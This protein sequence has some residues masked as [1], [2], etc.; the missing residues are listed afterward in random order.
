MHSWLSTLPIN[1][2][3]FTLHKGAFRDALALRYGWQPSNLPSNCVCGAHFS[4][5]HA[6]SCAKGG[7]PTLRHNEVRDIAAKLLSE[8]CT[9]VRI[10]PRLQPLSG[11]QIHLAS[12]NREDNARLDISANGFW[13]G[14]QERSMFDVR[15]FNP[16]APSNKSSSLVSIYKKH[17]R[18]KKRA[19]GQRVREVKHACFSP[20][21]VLIQLRVMEYGWCHLEASC[22]A[23][24]LKITVVSRPRPPVNENTKGEKHACLTS[25]TL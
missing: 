1:E 12:A 16:Y 8:V 22:E 4:V 7:F 2:H 3:G 9:E 21:D 20:L 5:E 13:G 24:I 18:E 23:S 25:R 15:V 6:L 19:Y 17:E 11:E 14:Q 10:E